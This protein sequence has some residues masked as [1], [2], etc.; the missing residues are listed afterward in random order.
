MAPKVK[1][2]RKRAR[3]SDEEPDGEVHAAAVRELR[4]EQR[5]RKSAGGV[6]ADKLFSAAR[7]A[8][9]AAADAR[10]VR[11]E[12]A[13]SK[14]VEE[15]SALGNVPSSAPSGLDNF[16]TATGLAA[17][18]P[19][20][21]A[22]AEYVARRMRELRGEPEP[23]ASQPRGRRALQVP[24]AQGLQVASAEELLSNPDR[25]YE[26]PLHLNP[27]PSW[28]V[29]RRPGGGAAEGGG[30]STGTG[31]IMLAGTGIS[32]VALPV[33][34]SA[35]NAAET[36]AAMAAY[37]VRRAAGGRGG[38]GISEAPAAPSGLRFSTGPALEDEETLRVLEATTTTAA[39]SVTA[40]YSAHRREH[41]IA[42]RTAAS[43][44]AGGAAGGRNTA[45]FDTRLVP[46]ELR[47][48]LLPAETGGGTRAASAPHASDDAA[49][50]KFKA[51]ELGR[52]R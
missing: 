48:G 20:E 24:G 2:L 7:E 31:G 1:P 11:P 22:K 45:L 12:D 46:A 49:F 13:A 3:D 39:G 35:R 33:S 10:P 50:K 6:D 27:A 36:G 25:M 26:L 16:A 52:N 29:G 19:L 8:A 18:D 44:G 43:G 14:A 5:L 34:F 21:A 4:E 28:G 40:N 23:E 30:D 51:R 47:G 17:A 38:A 15:L 9:K 41:A 42:T 37:L 32:E